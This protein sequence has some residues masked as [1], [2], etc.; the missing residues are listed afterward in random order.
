MGK[1]NGFGIGPSVQPM[2]L[3]IW[4][5]GQP[6]T[7]TLNSGLN[8]SLFFLDTEG[9]SANN[10]SENYDAKI[11]AVATLLS[12]HLLYNSV[13]IIDQ[14][15]IDY[16]EVLARRTQ[17]FALRSQMS[18]SKWTQDFNQDLLSFPP[19]IWV[20]QDFY[21]DTIDGETPQQWLHR[22]MKSN[23]RENENYQ[24][25]ILDIF[26]SVD[27]H[28]LFLPATSKKLLNNLEYANEGQL[29]LEYKHE[30]D[31][32]KKKLIQQIKPKERQNRAVNGQEL[33]ILVQI[34]VNAANDGSFSDIPS[35]WDAF[36]ER[37]QTTATEDCVNFYET[38]L[39][40][41]LIDHHKGEPVRGDELKNWHTQTM[42]K[43]QE[44]L[45]Y[46]LRGLSD[47]L[48]EGFV[49]LKHTIGIINERN[50]DL[51]EKKA[52]LK[53]TQLHKSYEILVEDNLRNLKFPI[54]S[55][56]LM[57]QAS[58]LKEKVL[59]EF[60][61]KLEQFVNTDLI[62]QSVKVLEKAL[63]HLISSNELHNYREME[64]KFNQVRKE[65][66]H[67]MSHSVTS[68]WKQGSPI[69][70]SF[71][72]K[73]L[74]E[75]TKLAIDSFRKRLNHFQNE[76]IFESQNLIL[77]T[78]LETKEKEIN[79]K[80][81]GLAQVKMESSASQ[82][83]TFF[84]QKTGDI[85]YPLNET[86]LEVKLGSEISNVIRDFENDVGDFDLYASY[87]SYQ[88]QLRQH[89][90]EICDER[91]AE[92]VKAFT[93][94]VNVPLS[95]AKKIIMLS[96]EQYSTVFSLKQF[97]STVGKYAFDKYIPIF[98]LF[99][100]IK[101]VCLLHLDEGE[102]K[103][104]SYNFKSKIIDVYIMNDEEILFLLKSKD[105]LYSKIVSFFQWLFWLIGLG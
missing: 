21:Q 59:K 50:I 66:V 82:L 78:E 42:V 98:Y 60:N 52:N 4:I 47:A 31:N 25:S 80:N 83:I 13:K 27:C 12:S 67:K 95:K 99:F 5:W 36:V 58:K 49:N 7:I 97:V 73:I 19:L 89:L 74:E 28:T 6:A 72:K 20:V 103:Y 93:Q 105:T 63:N 71:L 11:F 34:L 35:R 39:K 40:S 41:F 32:L 2:T 62:P 91:R 61:Q 17:L 48:E 33:A 51:N 14:S 44:L 45:K 1:S 15:D 70:P 64:I 87:H 81:E 26:K 92:N 3:G 79:A 30:R 57:Q 85:K 65:I 84:R 101:N 9:F 77:K 55:L 69:K 94:A 24:V 88:H 22:L 76:N 75:E 37:I 18:Q 8:I 16:L 29:T 38:E 46:L 10:V 53:I 102:P 56:E 96:A 23:I 86:E 90:A 100:Q 43:S 104:W 68:E 54:P